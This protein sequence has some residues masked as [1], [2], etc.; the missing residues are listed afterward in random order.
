MDGSFPV[1]DL[2]MKPKYCFLALLILFSFLTQAQ[3]K[4][5]TYR[6]HIK[7]AESPIVI[8]GIADDKAWESTD[9]A[10]DFFMVLP[11]DQGPATQESEIRMAYDDDHIY[12]LAI[13]YN[14]TRGPNYVESLRRDFAFGK[15]DNFLLFLDP[16][17][18]QT[19]GFT[20]GSNAAGAQWDG[21]MY[22]GS[23][24]DLSWDSKWVSEVVRDED[25]W[26]FEMALPF[27]S[28]RYEKG[29][30]E[31]GINFSRLDLKTSEK[32]SWT[33]IPRQFPTSSLALAGTL[34]WDAPPPAPKFNASLIPY[35]LG[36][37]GEEEGNVSTSDFKYGGDIKLSLSSSLNLDLTINP[38]FSQVE[39]DRQV[40]NLDRFELFFPERRQFFLEN[41]DLFANFGYPT[42]RPFFSR[43]IGLGVPIDA[44]ARVSGNL[45]KDWRL[46]VMD[47]QTASVEETGQPVQNFGVVSLQRRVFSRSN[48]NLM[49]VNKES[50]RYPN[51]ADSLRTLFP[52]FN[53]NLGVE[54]NLGSA[55][56][57][58]S[59]KA[60]LLKSF[61]PD[62]GDKGIAQAAN[63]S[64]TNRQWSWGIQEEF[65]GDS[66]SAEVGFVPRNSYIRLN[67]FVGFLFFPK[68]GRIVSHG[69]IANASHFFNTDFR[70]TDYQNSIAYTL[71]YT[72]RSR[73]E[74][75]LVQE[76]VE[77]LDPFDPTR[78]GKGT[79]PAG[80]KNSWSTVRLQYESKPQALFTYL[81]DS[82]LGGYYEDGTRFYFGS[83]LGYRF[84]PYVSLST[85]LSYNNFRM[86]APWNTTEFWLIG[87]KADITFTNKI[88]FATL[89]Q[90]NEQTRNFN[91]NSRFQWRYQ[92]ASDLFL[93]FTSNERL[94]PF[95]GSTWNL[96]LKLTFWFN[97]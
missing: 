57:L 88:F 6:I 93:V 34:V 60:F 82:S 46:G 41:A 76:F 97:P 8:D 66:Y 52:K 30:R 27:K 20:F 90:Y 15:N 9:V 19:T 39:V 7:R 71:N 17:N 87:S 5:G 59:G 51:E 72:N 54:Y 48:I 12:L 22:G 62:A 92:P 42:I 58:W 11:M 47:I 85:T 43:R 14:N 75:S 80:E 56:N 2:T 32:S 45:N 3:K 49:F 25:K 21:T 37:V 23:A 79:L 77:L 68:K 55:D 83:E 67:G 26:V 16:F 94:T 31:W 38:D 78:T 63:I 69:P 44:G 64:Y 96:T 65:V 28:I 95:T 4:N 40:T 86:P 53:R 33:P 10:K 35:T 13:F 29:V 84:Q 61:A 24:V 18:N 73:L 1:S 81:L 89:F 36:V 50:F 70:S 91:L 74:A